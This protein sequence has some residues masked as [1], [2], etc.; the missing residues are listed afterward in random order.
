[1]AAPLPSTVVIECP[2]C[3]TRYQL[4]AE[5][6][7][8]RGRKV[9]C[10]HCGETWQAKGTPLM[11][12]TST[13]DDRLDPEAEAALDAAFTAAEPP[14]E[15][16][17]VEDP[18]EEGRLKTIAAIK[19]AIAPKPGPGES[20]SEGPLDAAGEQGRRRAFAQRLAAL[21]RRSPLGRARRLARI[22]AVAALI[23]LIVGAVV[24]RTEIVRWAP[25]LAGAYEALGLGVNVVGLEFRDVTTLVTLRGGQNVMQVD[26]R[27]YS[28]AARNVTVPPVLVT[29]LDERGA[30]LYEWSTRPMV[31]VL[32][33]GEVADFSAQLTAPPPDAK[34]VRLTFTNG[35]GTVEAPV[36]APQ[37]G[38]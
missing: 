8:P 38:P 5:T 1:M 14:A 32:E 19:A 9:A 37:A 33:P 28:V 25:D 20:P 27:I 35:S 31:R 6:I 3:G 4:P 7:G 26:G 34:L 29:L 15:P 22:V 16:P 36:A 12:S 10:A 13:T 23:I 2:K 24:F 18:N 11:P 21:S 17:P 30:T